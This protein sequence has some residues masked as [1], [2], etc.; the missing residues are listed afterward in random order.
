[1]DRE[2]KRGRPSSRNRSS[3]TR[4]ERESAA[5]AT[6][7]FDDAPSSLDRGDTPANPE[8]QKETDRSTTESES[9]RERERERERE[10]G[11]TDREREREDSK[12][13]RISV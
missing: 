5:S 7:I 12:M 11:Q 4:L 2:E 10:Q 6:A 3:N 13:D 8:R 1:M 9:E